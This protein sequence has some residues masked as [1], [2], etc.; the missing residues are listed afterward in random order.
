MKKMR[1]K[2]ILMSGLLAA[3]MMLGTGSAW[4]EQKRPSTTEPTIEKTVN[5]AK[6]VTVSNDVKFSF[7]QVS[8]ADGVLAPNE[9]TAGQFTSLGISELTFTDA[10]WTNNTSEEGSFKNSVTTAL[11]DKTDAVG[12]YT[13]EVKE[14][15]PTQ[16]TEEYGWV[17]V[18]TDSYFVHV[19][20]DK[21]NAHTY[22]VT[23]ENVADKTGDKKLDKLSFTNTYTKRG[24]Q[25][26]K[27][28]ASLVISKNVTNPDYVDK[29]TYYT[30]EITFTRSS[31]TGS[32]VTSLPAA[33]KVTFD[34]DKGEA[35]STGAINYGAAYKFKL[36]DGGSVSFSDIPAGTTYTLTESGFKNQGTTPVKYT[37]TE[38]GIAKEATTKSPEGALIGEKEN[39]VDVS[40]TYKDVTVTGVLTSI[41]P[42]LALIVVA[43]VAIA[44]Y[45][46][47][48]KKVRRA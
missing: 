40:N 5:V 14:F 13:F 21:D 45:L 2:A 44:V 22:S 38:N 24:N 37:V 43:A 27:N 23:K 17:S 36:K 48:R 9:E 1:A 10:A 6:G 28:K 19:Y 41:A 47:V 34:K 12:E 8:N 35:V 26:N 32:E 20:V 3:S 39:K 25:D 11:E 7:T 29:N 16:T 46:V 4:A 33:N 42:F 15:A 30:F 18:D 31:T